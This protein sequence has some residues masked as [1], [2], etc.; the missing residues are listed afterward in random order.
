M[1]SWCAQQFQANPVGTMRVRM[2]RT[3]AKAMQSVEKTGI[4]AILDMLAKG[5]V[6]EIQL[7]C[8]VVD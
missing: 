8:Q 4:D 6:G 5:L 2:G 1:M 3:S 7:Y